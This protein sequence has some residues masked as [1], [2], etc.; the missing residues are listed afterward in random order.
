MK[1][2]EIKVK[3]ELGSRVKFTQDEMVSI[4]LFVHDKKHLLPKYHSRHKALEKALESFSKKAPDLWRG[5]YPEEVKLY[6]VGSTFSPKGYMSASQNKDIAKNFAHSTK[7]MVHI[8]GVH[9][10]PYWS[11]NI[12]HLQLPQKKANPQ[13]FEDNE[14][15]WMID[16]LK[17]EGEWLI[18]HDTKL[19]VVEERSEGDYTIYEVEPA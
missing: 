5:L 4:A 1:L 19:K 8:K 16:E 14:G 6:Q 7:K 9:A 18:G 10:F 2:D 12:E 13:A 3:N 11:W 15:D 17:K